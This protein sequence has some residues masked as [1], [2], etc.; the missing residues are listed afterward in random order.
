MNRFLAPWPEVAVQWDANCQTPEAC[1]AAAEPVK[2]LKSHFF[3]P[4]ER[5]FSHLFSEDSVPE[6]RDEVGTCRR[7]RTEWPFRFT[8]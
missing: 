3:L 1:G 6:E 8:D 5:V 7:K 4:P 2:Q